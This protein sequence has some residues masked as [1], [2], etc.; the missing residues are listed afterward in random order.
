MVQQTDSRSYVGKDYEYKE[1]YLFLWPKGNNSDKQQ[2]VC[3]FCSVVV[4]VISGSRSRKLTS[5]TCYTHET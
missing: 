5:E 2:H 1:T 4:V 3:W